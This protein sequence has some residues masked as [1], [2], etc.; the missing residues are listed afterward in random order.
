M[1]TKYTLIGEASDLADFGINTT[2]YRGP[3]NG[4]LTSGEVTTP[5]AGVNNNDKTD[6]LNNVL[7]HC[8]LEDESKN[9]VTFYNEDEG[10]RPVENYVNLW[11]SLRNR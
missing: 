1:V 7:S 3:L 10:N 9:V 4:V 2:I 5:A 8:T 6:G 11:G